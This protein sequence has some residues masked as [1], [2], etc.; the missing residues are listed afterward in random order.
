MIKKELASL[1]DKFF[2]I[3]ISVRGNSSLIHSKFCSNFCF[4]LLYVRNKTTYVRV[5]RKYLRTIFKS[6]WDTSIGY[7]FFSMVAPIK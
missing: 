7:F 1:I 4:F 5:I 3:L 6:F 2:I